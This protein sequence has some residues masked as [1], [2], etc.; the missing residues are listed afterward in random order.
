MPVS[1]SIGRHPVDGVHFIYYLRSICSISIM[2]IRI[3]LTSPPCR[4]IVGNVMNVLH[5]GGTTHT[6]PEFWSLRDALSRVLRLRLDGFDG[7]LDMGGEWA[8]RDK[9]RR[10]RCQ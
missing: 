8:Y 3:C 10:I 4:Y 6:L 5:I 2:E 9:N 7:S 1:V